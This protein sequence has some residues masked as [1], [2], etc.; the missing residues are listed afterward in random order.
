MK[1][2]DYYQPED[3]KEAFGLMDRLKGG[4]RYVAGGT[5]IICRI[6]Q[7]VVQPDAL[8][9]LRRIKA[10]KGIH[11]N[12]GT[13]LGSMTL[14]REIE[15]DERTAREH[16]C[17]AQAVGVLATPQIRNV[18]TLGGNLCN[19][20]PSAD[21]APPLLVLEASLSLEGPGGTRDVPI[22]EFFTGPGQTS[23]KGSEVLTHVRIPSQGARAGSAFVKVGRLSEDIAIVNAAALLVMDGEICRKCRLA[24]GAVAPVPLRLRRAEALVEGRRIEEDLL[25]QVSAIAQ[26]EV[27]PISDVRATEAYRR[28]LSGVLVKRAMIDALKAVG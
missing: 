9:S 3:L 4:A 25:H 8:I 28:T 1:R 17:L 14:L 2:F 27:Q 21:S 20:A 6:K 12:G 10:L 11:H 26:E 18:A 22:E 5:D 24:V 13:T 23:L 7:K 19:A 16:R 15:R